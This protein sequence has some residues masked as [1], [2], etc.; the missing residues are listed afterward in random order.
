MTI[1]FV[2]L[3]YGPDEPAGIERSI[4][5]LVLGLRARGHQAHV[6]AA[7]P[8]SVA[9]P[10][11]II[12]LRALVL[13]RPATEED[14]LAA[15]ANAPGLSGEV[16]A[17]LSELDA[18]LVCWTD[19]TWG[20]GYLAPHP[21]IAT[22]LMVRVLRTDTYLHQALA[23]HP[24]HVLTN[25]AFLCHQAAA[26]GLDTQRWHVVP[27]ALIT[28]GTPP[29]DAVR[30]HLRQ[31][32][33]VRIVTRAEPHKGIAELITACPSDL[34]RDVNI[35]LA[36][37]AFEYWPGMQREVITACQRLADDHPRVR[38][39]SALPWHGVQPFLAA[40]SCTVIAST[41]PETFCNTALEALSVATPVITFDLGHVPTLIGDAGTV[42]P[43]AQ[44]ADGLWKAVTDLLDSSHRYRHASQAG[45]RHAARH[46]PDL[47]AETF[48]AAVSY[49]P[50]TPRSTA[51]TRRT[52]PRAD[53]TP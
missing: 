26:V 2:L 23:R 17:L 22:A 3:T 19:A 41:S 18:D 4:A 13:P 1:M 30:E 14:L 53:G 8:G 39:C 27:N 32:G 50:P 38:L 12:R 6:I 47:V 35:V 29:A 25:S 10:A 11:E 15:V 31:R 37:A 42:V 46:Q 52:T 7:G 44:S 16:T 36:S 9:D 51:R 45:P 48:L 43:L 28:P 21:G 20:L 24:D 49:R 34:G 33:P 40:A 5:A